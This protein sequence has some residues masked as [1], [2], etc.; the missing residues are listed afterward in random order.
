MPSPALADGLTA[1]PKTQERENF[2]KG[3]FP[4]THF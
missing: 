4:E 1:A 2:Q 3:I